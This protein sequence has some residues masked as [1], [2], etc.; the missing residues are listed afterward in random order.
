MDKQDQNPWES[1]PN[2]KNTAELVEKNT[3]KKILDVQY[4]RVLSV[5]PYMILSAIICAILASIYLRYQ[6]DIFELSTSIVVE[7]DQEVS[8]GKALFSTRDPL[9]NQV[10]ILKSPALSRR[11]VDSMGLNFHTKADG[12]FLDKDLYETYSWTIIEKD[13]LN[14]SL[15]SF[16]VFPK[17]Q[18]FTWVSGNKKGSGIFGF[19]FRING[20]NVILKKIGKSISNNFTCYETNAE[21][22]AFGLASS[23]RVSS[24]SNS[25]VIS[26]TLQDHVPKRAIDVFKNLVDNYSDQMLKEKTKSLRQTAAFIQQKVTQISD[27]LDSLESISGSLVDKKGNIAN[28]K[29]GSLYLARLQEYNAQL[30]QI[31]LQKNGLAFIEEMLS[32]QNNADQ[33]WSMTGLSDNY[34]QSLAGQ[35]MQLN[36]ER[37]RLSNTVTAQN[38]KL[39][40]IDNKIEDMRTRMSSQLRTYRQKIEQE[41]NKFRQKLRE[42]NFEVETET[43]LDEKALIEKIRLENIK[44]SYLD[45]LQRREDANIALA[46]VAVKCSVITPA[47]IPSK[48][49][50]PLRQEIMFGAFF[51]GLWIPLIFTF[52]RELLNRKIISKFQL[53]QMLSVPV[54]AELEQVESKSGSL[55]EVGGNERSIFGEQIRNLRANLSFYTKPDKPFVIMLTSNMSGEGKSFLSANLARSFALQGKKVALLEFDLRRPKLSSR[56]GFKPVKGLTHYLI[57]NAEYDELPQQIAGDE[58]F[59]FFAS[60]PIPPNPSELMSSPKMDELFDN[61][62]KNFD[63]IVV[64]TPPYG[65]VA[66]AQLITSK[67]DITLVVTRFQFTVIDQVIEIENWHNTGVF[68]KIA[69]LFNG[70]RSR[71]YYG[72]KYGYYAYKRKYGYQYYH[73]DKK[74]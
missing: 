23:L 3:S 40:A 52:I 43:A 45:L 22:E 20:S 37:D 44:T 57:G 74:K 9:N 11:V 21:T 69:V 49:L 18:N 64:D 14:T 51:I 4:R 67:V 56:F 5:W 33:K 8:I 60:G 39:I 50:S 19:P 36:I 17:G 34:L 27:E 53:Q 42:T 48:P 24:A 71:G 6:I 28:T 10:A 12:R 41:E 16:E 63:V 2:L 15:L 1:Y 35:Y 54:L 73:S 26:M 62:Y 7:E 46:S 59:Q 38:P 13:S 68:P 65:I 55:L 61:L 29:E 32:N 31:E 70:I 25:N 66:D 72:Y 47:R 58:N 30:K